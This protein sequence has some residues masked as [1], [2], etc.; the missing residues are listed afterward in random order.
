MRLRKG[1]KCCFA[2]LIL[3]SKSLPP[4]YLACLPLATTLSPQPSLL[5]RPMPLGHI[6]GLP[7]D[8]RFSSILLIPVWESGRSKGIMSL[9]KNSGLEFWIV[10]WIQ[11]KVSRGSLF[12]NLESR[13]S[14]TFREN[15][16]S[17]RAGRERDR[18]SKIEKKHKKRLDAVALSIVQFLFIVMISQHLVTGITMYFYFSTRKAK[19]DHSTSTENAR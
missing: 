3:S 11:C 9:D 10:L 13:S 6:Y 12:I 2:P 18:L 4:C 17:S 8:D 1:Y 16:D 7:S 19:D 5:L 14:T 15:C